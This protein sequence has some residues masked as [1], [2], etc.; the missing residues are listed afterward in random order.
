MNN[1]TYKERFGHGIMSGMAAVSEQFLIGNLLDLA[2]LEKQ[3]STH[4][5]CLL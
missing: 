1:K 3:R 2:K 5:S 4:K